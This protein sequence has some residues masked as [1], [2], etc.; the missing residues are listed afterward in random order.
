[1][2]CTGKGFGF[3]QDGCHAQYG[4]VPANA[5]A[6]LPKSLSFAQAANA[7]LPVPNGFIELPLADAVA[8]YQ[9]VIAGASDKIVLIP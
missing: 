3:Y 9:Q 4:V 8:A 2:R 6:L 5:V 7:G 1:M